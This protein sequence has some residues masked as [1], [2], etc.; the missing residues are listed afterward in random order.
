M[1]TCTFQQNEM[2]NGLVSWLMVVAQYFFV[3]LL[4]FMHECSVSLFSLRFLYFFLIIFLLV[5]FFHV[6][7]SILRA[8]ITYSCPFTSILLACILNNVVHKSHFFCINLIIILKCTLNMHT[9][10]WMTMIIRFTLYI[11]FFYCKNQIRLCNFKM[12][13]ENKLMTEREKKNEFK[14]YI[15]FHLTYF[16]GNEMMMHRISHF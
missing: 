5:V 9:Y 14:K 12:P 3:K 1:N 7:D 6:N 13:P 15:N 16:L 10:Y 4:V 11:Y 8:K 2:D